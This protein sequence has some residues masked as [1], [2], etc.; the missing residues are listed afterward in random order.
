MWKPEAIS[1][2]FFDDS[3]SCFL[4]EGLS[5]SLVLT[6]LATLAGQQD[7]GSSSVCQAVGLQVHTFVHEHWGLSLGLQAHVVI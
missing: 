6:Y 5:L 1:D 7:H 2:V 4:R 3:L